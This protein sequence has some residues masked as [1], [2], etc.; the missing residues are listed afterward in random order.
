M[1]QQN[2]IMLETACAIAKKTRSKG[3]L[4]YGDII[5]DYEALATIAQEKQVDLILAIKDESSFQEAVSVFKKVLR[6][7]DVPLG[8]MNQMKMAIIQ[9]LSKGLVKKGDK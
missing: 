9:A 8:R 2:R 3:V 5:E 4:L 6:I 1:K 7:P